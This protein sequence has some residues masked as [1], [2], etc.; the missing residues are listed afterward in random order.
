MEET[1]GIVLVVDDERPNIN[2]LVDLLGD[3]YTTL[4]AKNGEQALKRAFGNPT[5]DVILLDIMMP[6]VDGYE[7]LRRLKANQ[8]DP[9]HIG[10]FC[11]GHG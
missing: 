2:L 10:D 8:I 9:G 11:N 3:T 1:Q 6:G 4:I 5:P 7:V